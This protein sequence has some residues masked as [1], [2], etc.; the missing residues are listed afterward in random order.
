LCV[1]RRGAEGAK[2][3]Q[4]NFRDFQELFSAFPLCPLRLC[5]EENRY[6]EMVMMKKPL[7]ACL[8]VILGAVR[9]GFCATVPAAGTYQSDSM[10]KLYDENRKDGVGNFITTDFVLTAY[11]LLLNDLLTSIEKQVLYPTFTKL[12]HGLL[13]RLQTTNRDTPGR[14]M[15]LSYASVLTGLLEPEMPLPLQ[16]GE[17]GRVEAELKLID[18]HAG[19][20]SSS[21]LE[22]KEDFSQYVPRGKYSESEPLK[23]YFK[24]MMYAGRMGFFLKES[25]AT[26]VTAAVADEHM[27]V[28][29]LLGGTIMG[30]QQL[31]GFY[32]TIDGLLSFLSGKSDD[33]TLE[34]CLSAAGSLTGREARMKILARMKDTGR[35]PRIVA[36]PVDVGKLEA[37]V[38]IQEAAAG[39]KL[40]GQ[41][42]TPDAEV[43]Q[44]LTY[45]RV[46]AYR[47]KGKDTPFTLGV[48][49][50]RKVRTFPTILDIMSGL[51][52]EK[53]A[54]MLLSRGDSAYD[55]YDKQSRTA[56]NRLLASAAKPSS[57]PEMNLRAMRALIKKDSAAY[58]LNGA[59]GLWIRGKHSNVL[60]AKQ[61]YTMVARSLAPRS[62]R[63]KAFLEPVPDV[64][65]ALA[66]NLSQI[67]GELGKYE[68]KGEGTASVEVFAGNGFMK[69]ISTFTDA[70]KRLGSIA[71][72]Q[73]SASLEKTEVD[74]L[75]SLD[76]LLSGLLDAQ[77]HAIVVDVHTEPNSKMVVEEAVGNPIVVLR[78]ELRGARFNCYQF[79]QPL[80]RRLTDEAWGEMLRQGRVQGSL[81]EEILRNDG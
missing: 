35:L 79:K 72:K 30:D 27:A 81:S 37:G 70:M 21:V 43:F 48:I 74:Y 5:G 41:R 26:D 38:S 23:R 11:S 33:F 2:K 67:S 44:D 47:R 20:A 40:V 80:D 19:I 22:I 24:S 9:M 46:G 65:D 15:A 63:E 53:A 61:T 31:A 4:R 42:H 29:L 71:R 25:Q 68:E 52:F 55:N 69:R 8:I 75:N 17:A 32:R 39:I 10:F 54:K 62:D 1:H 56:A 64:Y 60:Y 45:T 36:I 16:E 58:G 77:D 76:R 57:I 50:G 12:T 3:A 18:Q 51:G 14:S 13:Q 66:A 7:W 28:A 49:N 6:G 73:Q 34:E 78:E 59:L